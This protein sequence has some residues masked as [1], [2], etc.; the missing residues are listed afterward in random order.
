MVLHA[1]V[2]ELFRHCVWCRFVSG[3]G[4][5][6]LPMSAAPKALPS[7]AWS[8]NTLNKGISHMANQMLDCKQEYQTIEEELEVS[9]IQNWDLLFFSDG[10]ATHFLNF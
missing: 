1:A 7:R 10:N 9:L 3:A 6:L 4:G 8:C 2:R 5:R